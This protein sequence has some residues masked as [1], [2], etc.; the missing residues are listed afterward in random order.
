MGKVNVNKEELFILG[1]DGSK[2]SLR[3]KS[4]KEFIFEQEIKGTY[5]FDGLCL[6]AWVRDS[7]EF[8]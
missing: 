4:K 8:P 2:S 5:F 7:P 3:W 6:V 1:Q